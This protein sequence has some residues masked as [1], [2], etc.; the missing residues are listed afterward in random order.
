MSQSRNHRGRLYVV[1]APS[2]AGKTSL[3]HA[4]IK[5]LRGD[6]HRIR[7]SISYTTRAPRPEERDGVDYHFVTE[8]RFRDMIAAGDF[9]EHARVFDRFYGT[10]RGETEHWLAAG[11]DVMLDIDWQSALQVRERAA[12]A[13]LIFIEPPSLET[14]EQRLRARGSEDEQS[15]ARR[16]AGAHDEMTRADAYDHRVVNDRFDEALAAIERIF[17][18]GKTGQGEAEAL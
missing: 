18:Q 14:L 15:I 3:T 4:L 12:D 10:A 2:G 17:R 7:F 5:R 6:G 9:L 1:S 16:L 13:V 11:H 8:Q